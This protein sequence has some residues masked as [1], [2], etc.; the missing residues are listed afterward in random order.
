MYNLFMWETVLL[1]F[2]QNVSILCFDSEIFL[3][4]EKI[5]ILAESVLKLKLVWNSRVIKSSYKI[6]LRKTT[7]YFEL[8]TRIFL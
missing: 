7:S 2:R 4:L 5:S 8:L 1:N 6:E 3:C